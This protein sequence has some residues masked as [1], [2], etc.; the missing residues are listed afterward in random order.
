MISG[1]SILVSLVRLVDSLPF[2]PPPVQRKRGRHQTY[3]DQLI[4]KAVVVMII[5]R[6]YTAWALLAFLHQDDPVVQQL[7]PLLTEHGQFPSRRTWERRLAALPPTLPGLIG[8]LGRHL[9]TILKPGAQQGHGTACD[10]TMVRAHGG[11][12][13]K[14]DREAGVVPHSSIDTEAH[15]SKSGWHGWWYGWKLPL[16]V[17]LGPLRIPLAAEFTV[18]NV[19][20]SEVAP[21]LLI[22][23]PA[24]VRYVLGDQHYNTPELRA[25]C[26]RHHRELVATRRG[27]YPHT[28]GGVEVRRVFH[29]LRSQAIEPFNGLFKNLF[30]WGGQMPVKG[31]GRCQLLALGAVVLYQLVLLYQHHQHQ[32]V[33]VGIKALLRAA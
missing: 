30:E 14:K 32:L 7:R 12:W 24:E 1:A 22:Q 10:S 2:P 20:D 26:S 33:G 21:L 28:D 6:L 11:V 29:K 18:A 27:A 5:R 23:L 17:A 25:E 16:A 19:S 9:V 13:H 3:S 8:R 15:W 31:L 4:V